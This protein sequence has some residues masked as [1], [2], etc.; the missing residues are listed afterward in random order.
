MPK[1]PPE[2]EAQV[3]KMLIEH[4][5]WSFKKTADTIGNISESYV[6]ATYKKHKK[7]LTKR[8][9]GAK[10]RI[11]QKAM[12]ALRLRK[13]HPD[14]SFKKIADTVDMSLPYIYKI[15]HKNTPSTQPHK[16]KETIERERIARLIRKC[17][18]K[19]NFFQA[20]LLCYKIGATSY[21][22]RIIRVAERRK[23]ENE[24]LRIY[25]HLSRKGLPESPATHEL[26]KTMGANI[27]NY[28]A[29]LRKT[30]DTNIANGQAKL[31]WLP[32]R[33]AGR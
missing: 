26:I 14:W 4:P 32:K 21:V 31:K 33:H 17:M 5:E 6:G 2:K 19:G 11:S 3:L 8:R 16:S 18:K 10:P 22:P 27:T 7:T 23:A 9:R 24:L 12:E 20:T 13:E 30:I 15:Y 29:K 25:G 28:E 1:K